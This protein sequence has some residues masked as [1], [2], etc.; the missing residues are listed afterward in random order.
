M[1]TIVDQFF[2]LKFA[3]CVTIFTFYHQIMFDKTM[4][5]EWGCIRWKRISKIKNETGL[6][7]NGRYKKMFNERWFSS[8]NYLKYIEDEI[9]VKKKPGPLYKYKTI[10]LLH[11]FAMFAVFTV[12]NMN[13]LQNFI[14]LFAFNWSTFIS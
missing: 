10:A 2:L 5:T 9:L 11:M 7:C 4:E 12:N 8:T 14:F 1:I 13:I 6:L 3:K